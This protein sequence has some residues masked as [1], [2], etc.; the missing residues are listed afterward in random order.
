MR[1]RRYQIAVLVVL[2][3]AGTIAYV[4]VSGR[5]TRGSLSHSVA[6]GV[7][8]GYFGSCH[9]HA[10]RSWS[11]ELMTSDGSVGGILYTVT[12]SGSC[13]HGTRVEEGRLVGLPPQVSGCIGVMDQLRLDDHLQNGTSTRHPGFF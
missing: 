3:V 10:P 9:V 1:R 5:L 13:W 2:A 7:G 12:T 8:T 11:C 4:T 6:A